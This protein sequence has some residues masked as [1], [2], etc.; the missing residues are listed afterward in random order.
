MAGEQLGFE[1]FVAVVEI[2]AHADFFRFFKGGDGV[3]IDV[4]RP[5]EDVEFAGGGQS[6][7]VSVRRARTIGRAVVR[8]A[9]GYKQQDG[10][11]Q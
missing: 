3:G 1:G 10:C 4:V 9:A 8:A 2:V 6:G 7:C 5:V 11:G